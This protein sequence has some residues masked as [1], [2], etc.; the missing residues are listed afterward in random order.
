MNGNIPSVQHAKLREIMAM[1]R[2]EK[3]VISMVLGC[4]NLNQIFYRP[5]NK[6]HG[7]GANDASQALSALKVAPNRSHASNSRATYHKDD[8]KIIHLKNSFN[9][10]MREEKILDINNEN[11]DD[12]VSENILDKVRNEK[13]GSNSLLK[14]ANEASTSKPTSSK[15]GGG[16]QLEK[17]DLDYYDSYEAKIYDLPRQMRAFC[18]QFD[19]HVNNRVRK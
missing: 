19:I 7:E 12:Y 17:D 14:E 16:Y 2:L 4:Q 9:K 1:R 6:G 11:R 5:I 8:V 3:L 18:D 10:L 15:S 13:Q